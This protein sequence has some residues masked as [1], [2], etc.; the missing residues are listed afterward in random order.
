MIKKQKTSWK[1][2]VCGLVSAVGYGLTQSEDPRF[3][4]I[5]QILVAIGLACTGLFAKDNS[6]EG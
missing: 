3:H 5:G 4:A 1:T 6:V 2:T